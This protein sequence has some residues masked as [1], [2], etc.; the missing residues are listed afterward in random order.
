MSLPSRRHTHK[1][2]KKKK[3]KKHSSYEVAKPMVRAPPNF[4]SGS[5]PTSFPLNK[6][7]MVFVLNVFWLADTG[8]FI[9]PSW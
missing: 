8:D 1:K 7:F 4:K 6:L 3:K 5:V 2:L 9:G